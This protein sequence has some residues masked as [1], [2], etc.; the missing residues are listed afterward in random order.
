MIINMNILPPIKLDEQ[1]LGDYKGNIYLYDLENE[2][3]NNECDNF[4]NDD[5]EISSKTLPTIF[6]EVAEPADNFD[7]EIDIVF[8]DEILII[9]N[10]KDDFKI[11]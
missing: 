4:I 9:K 3:D 2:T 5:I 8:D 6:D 10:I 1:I 7:T 11:D